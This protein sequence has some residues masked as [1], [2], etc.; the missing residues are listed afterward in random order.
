MNILIVNL[1]SALNLGDDAIMQAT[2]RALKESFPEAIITAAANDPDSWRKYTDISVVGSLAWWVI[3]RSRGAWRWRKPHAIMYA[4][5]LALAIGLYRSLN[6]KFLFGSAE[7]R[8]LLTAY[9]SAD[10]VLS[11]GGGNFYAHRPLSIA[12][13]WSL[14]TLATAT[15]SE[16]END[17]VTSIDRAD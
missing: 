5:L 4:G 1:H 10:L 15:T 7:Q 2:L 11:C 3:D 8:R 6:V 13:I 16:E 12:F 14:L 17:H 9:Y